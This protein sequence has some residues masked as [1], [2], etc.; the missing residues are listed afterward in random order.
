MT[1]R[2]SGRPEIEI[3][4][5]ICAKAERLAAQGLVT[6]QIA[7]VLDMGLSTLYEKQARFPELRD[8]IKNGR[9][10]GIAQVSNALYDNAINGDNVAC[11]FYLKNRDPDNWKDKRDHVHTG[12]AD[13]PLATVNLDPV[14][15]SKVRAK[16]LKDADC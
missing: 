7:R 15:Y 8:A 13:K 12:D 6:E 4:P 16:M 9:A 5:D 3:T 1:A 10:K 14:E 11:I 2:P